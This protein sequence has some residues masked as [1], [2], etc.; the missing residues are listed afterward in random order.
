MRPLIFIMPNTLSYHKLSL[1]LQYEVVADLSCYT[2]ICY[3]LKFIQFFSCLFEE[4]SYDHYQIR[5]RYNLH[6]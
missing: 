1:F 3:S 2:D 4:V 6:R 5:L